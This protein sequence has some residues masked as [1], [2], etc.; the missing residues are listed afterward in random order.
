MTRIYATQK[1]QISLSPLLSRDI[2]I[3]EKYLR[4]IRK[5]DPFPLGRVV[6]Y[7]LRAFRANRTCIRQKQKKKR[8]DD[9]ERE[10][11]KARPRALLR[12][13]RRA[14]I[15]DAIVASRACISQVRV[16]PRD[17]AVDLLHVRNDDQT[18]GTH[19]CTSGDPI[20]PVVPCNENDEMKI[21][22]RRGG[23]DTRD[24]LGRG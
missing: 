2:P 1:K 7:T 20:V 23:G 9:H 24:A 3:A 14:I 17:P 22:S 11:R 15:A 13:H 4:G 16:P 8:R 21:R 12:E 10:A 19:S 18:E 6:R 5:K